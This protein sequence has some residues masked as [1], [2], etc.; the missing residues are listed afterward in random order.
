MAS[1][2]FQKTVN[3]LSFAEIMAKN[4]KTG[5]DCVY[6]NSEFKQLVTLSWIIKF[7]LIFTS[8]ILSDFEIFVLRCAY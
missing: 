4:L 5:M 8:L 3:K 7:G 2:Q 1:K 6:I